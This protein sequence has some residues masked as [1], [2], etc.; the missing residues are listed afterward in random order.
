MARNPR[1]QESEF[2]P[3]FGFE[4]IDS[5]PTNQGSVSQGKLTKAQLSQVVFEAIGL[6]SNLC[7]DLVVSFF[8][9]IKEAL[10]R[11]ENVKI[12]GFASFHLRDKKARPGRNPKTGEEAEVSA[13]RVVTFKPS[14]ALRH[15]IDVRNQSLE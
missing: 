14:R 7:D 15:L 2:E 5:L 13:R 4:E 9:E 10:V 1:D 11:G 8:N 3:Q 12:P 6:S